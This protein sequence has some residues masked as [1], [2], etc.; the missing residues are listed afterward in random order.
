MN[1]KNSSY[2]G[3]LGRHYIQSIHKKKNIKIENLGLENELSW[4]SANLEQKKSWI[5][6]QKGKMEKQY[7]RH[8]HLAFKKW[9]IIVLMGTQWKHGDPTWLHEQR[10]IMKGSTLKC[11]CN[12]AISEIC[13]P[14]CALMW[15]CRNMC[16]CVCTE[17]KQEK[18]RDKHTER[19]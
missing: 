15:T 7:F 14:L 10:K 13:D 19:Q 12:F 8:A 16:L 18:N 1:G 6:S 2:P 11:K 17:R 5:G 9:Q 4:Q 3:V